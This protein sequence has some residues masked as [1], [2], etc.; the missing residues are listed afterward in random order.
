MQGMLTKVIVGLLLLCAPTGV[1]AQSLQPDV[2]TLSK[3]RVVSAVAQGS[4][5]V[6]G[7]S[8]TSEVQ[9]LTA[10][11]LDGPQKGEVVTF[12]N[13]FTQLSEGEVFYL[14]H[15]ESPSDGTEFYS[16]ADPYRLPILIGLTVVFLILLFLFG[17]IQG[18][19]GLLAL[20][21]SFVLIFY[22]LLPGIVAVSTQMLPLE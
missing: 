3:A 21:G 6:P 14:R 17:G 11:V 4:E 12:V 18:M 5:V 20:L 22:L 15:L 2:E 13:D 9:T 7:T 10:E 16:V 1:F 8:L 19:R